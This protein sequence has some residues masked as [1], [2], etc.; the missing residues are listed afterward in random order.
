MNVQTAVCCRCTVIMMCSDCNQYIAGMM[1][2]HKFLSG[3]V[4]KLATDDGQD[5]VS[6]LTRLISVG[7]SMVKA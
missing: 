1:R 4:D 2:Q 7:S 3:V 6:R 5:A